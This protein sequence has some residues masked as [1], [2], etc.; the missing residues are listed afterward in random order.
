MG[1]TLKFYVERDYGLTEWEYVG[2]YP[3]GG[4]MQVL[5]VEDWKKGQESLAQFEAWKKENGK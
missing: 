5:S 2:E 3:Q 4:N 1:E